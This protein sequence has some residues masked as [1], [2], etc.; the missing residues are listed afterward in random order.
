MVLS[1]ALDRSD[2]YQQTLAVY[3]NNQLVFATIIATAGIP[4]S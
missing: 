2:L 3:D 4:T 1:M